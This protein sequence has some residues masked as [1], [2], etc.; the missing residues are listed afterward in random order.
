MPPLVSVDI[1]M[2]HPFVYKA[3][4]AARSCLLEHVSLRRLLLPVW[5][6]ALPP[7]RTAATSEKQAQVA[8]NMLH[9]YVHWNYAGYTGKSESGGFPSGTRTFNCAANHFSGVAHPVHTPKRFSCGAFL[10]IEPLTIIHPVNLDNHLCCGDPPHQVTSTASSSGISGLINLVRKKV[11]FVLLYS[12]KC[13]LVFLNW[14]NGQINQDVKQHRCS[15]LASG[16]FWTVVCVFVTRMCV[17]WSQSWPGQEEARP[18]GV[19]LSGESLL[20][21]TQATGQ[22]LLS[23]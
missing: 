23:S 11:C 22:C 16:A 21:R 14:S 7:L 17:S 19:W 12:K 5:T 8:W 6:V 3:G 15:L 18:C 1:Q 2:F 13:R 10:F 4:P 20:D 9:F